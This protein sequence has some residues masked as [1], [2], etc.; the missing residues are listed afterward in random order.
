MK[1]AACEE[2]ARTKAACTAQA[3][4]A[5]LAK[6]M[7]RLLQAAQ[8]KAALLPRSLGAA[9]VE[10]TGG[11][12][13]HAWEGVASSMIDEFVFLQANQVSNILNSPPTEHLSSILHLH[14]KCNAHFSIGLH[15]QFH[16]FFKL[17]SI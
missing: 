11:H 5:K 15:P 17:T 8:R 7:Q 14:L 9:A 4:K 10:R 2:A 16:H 1:A 13:T 3:A 6:A 12:E